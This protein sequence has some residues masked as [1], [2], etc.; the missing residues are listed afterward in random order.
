[1]ADA[2]HLAVRGPGRD[3]ELVGHRR[4]GERVVAA[5]LDLVRQPG[6]D[7]RAVVGDDARLPVQQRPRLADLAA[8]RLDD[9]LVAEA[10]AERRR[11]RAEPPDQLDRDARVGGTAGA[12]GDDEPVGRER[13]GLVGRDRVVPDGDDLGAELLE[14]GARGCR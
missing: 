4:R 5:D 8:E 6:E 13:L 2:H 3:D 14:A 11:R 12:G 10:D 9:R 1:M 7:A